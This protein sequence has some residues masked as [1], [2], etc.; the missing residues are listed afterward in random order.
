V[1]AIGDVIE[2]PMLAHKA[3]MEGVVVAELIAGKLATVPYVAVPNVVYTY[4]ELATV[5]FSEREARD[6]G[7]SVISA[8]VPLSANPRAQCMHATEGLVKVVGNAQN[9]ELLG[10]HILAP[11][12]S[13]MI[14]LGS[15]ALAKRVTIEELASLP[16]AH[17]T[18]SEA[19][20]AAC[21]AA[22]GQALYG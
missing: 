13:E 3:E 11:C 16:F 2:G 7:L 10:L 4:P 9:Q 22:I 6:R 8:S 17:P 5:G 1:F 20:K 14:A 15:L 18:L 12:A 21:G 19:I